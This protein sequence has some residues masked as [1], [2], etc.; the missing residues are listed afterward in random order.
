MKISKSSWHYR[1]LVT[2]SCSV[3]NNLCDY[4]WKVIFCIFATIFAVV[5]VG[6]LLPF[7]LG[8]V[9]NTSSFSISQ[10]A[11]ISNIFLYGLFTTIMGY[12]IIGIGFV[13]VIVFIETWKYFSNKLSKKEP[14]E[15]LFISYLK[16]KKGKYCSRIEFISK[17]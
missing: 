17:D 13:L 8:M 16:A 10:I 14:K 11:S 2:G 15:S 6:V 1:L 12:L 4:F 5:M 7:S 3:P 9:I